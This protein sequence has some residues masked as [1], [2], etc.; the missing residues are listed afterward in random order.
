VALIGSKK[1]NSAN[2]CC[3]R[4]LLFCRLVAHWGVPQ[5]IAG[6]YQES[7]RAGRDGLKSR[8]RIYYSRQERSAI[9]FLLR[10]ELSHAK[11]EQKKEQVKASYKRFESMINYCQETK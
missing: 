2:V 9:E 7:G 1:W 11:T 10:K 4:F 6:Y 5:S 3:L 8:C